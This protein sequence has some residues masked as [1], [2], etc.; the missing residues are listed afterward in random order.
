M[1]EK[2]IVKVDP[3]LKDIIPNYIASTKT[4][5]EAMPQLLREGKFDALWGIGH[6]LHGSGG[7]FG[8]DF[9]TELGARLEVTARKTDRQ[10][11]EAQTEELRDF[12]DSLEIEYA[13]QE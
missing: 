9:L 7:G 10:A 6:N 4:K 11:I 5:L 8:L 13:D 1:S 12:L 2:K 3:D